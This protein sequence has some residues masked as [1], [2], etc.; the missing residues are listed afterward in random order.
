[1]KL[2]RGSW[3]EEAGER[4]LDVGVGGLMEQDSFGCCLLR[5]EGEGRRMEE[6]VLIKRI[7]RKDGGRM[8]E[9]WRMGS[10]DDGGSSFRLKY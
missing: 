3:R 10:V 2:S 6:V 8:E 5:D 4:K 1:M 7:E 9:E